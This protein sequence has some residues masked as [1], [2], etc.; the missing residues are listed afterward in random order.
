[1]KKMEKSL[2]ALELRE[3]SPYLVGEVVDVMEMGM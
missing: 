2:E 3:R 1:M